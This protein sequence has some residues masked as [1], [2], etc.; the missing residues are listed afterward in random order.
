MEFRFEAWCD[1]ESKVYVE[2]KQF[3]T[4]DAAVNYILDTVHRY[5]VKELVIMHIDD[6]ETD[7]TIET[8]ESF[9]E[10]INYFK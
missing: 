6:L 2:T 4:L 8:V 3:R 5:D 9:V 7:E 1:S 10:G